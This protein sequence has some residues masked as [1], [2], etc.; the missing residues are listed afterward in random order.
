MLDVISNF[1]SDAAKQAELRAWLR[2]AAE[3]ADLSRLRDMQVG[4]RGTCMRELRKGASFVQTPPP[5]TLA[6]APPPPLPA[7]AQMLERVSP[8]VR[9]GMLQLVIPILQKRPDAALRVQLRER[10]EVRTDI[11]LI[12]QD[13]TRTLGGNPKAKVGSWRSN[14]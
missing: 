2:G 3:S 1:T 4:G 11:R 5:H 10:R 8:E 12:L 14:G 13:K 7:R 6:A 9:H